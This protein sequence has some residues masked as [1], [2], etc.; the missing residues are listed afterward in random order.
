[1]TFRYIGSQDSSGQLPAGQG[2]DGRGGGPGQGFG[3]GRGGGV[4]LLIAWHVAVPA[5]KL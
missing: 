4:P 2:L 5:G 3:L 1:M